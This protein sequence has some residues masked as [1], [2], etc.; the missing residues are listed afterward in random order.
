MTPHPW[1]KD[2]A[3]VAAG[4]I[5]VLLVPAVAMQFSREIDWGAMDF[6][7]AAIL[8][9]AA[10]AVAAFALRRLRTRGRRL[11]AMAAVGATVLVVWA[12][13]AVGL[14]H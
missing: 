1:R 12:E 2:L 4:T 3:L 7:A 6:L 8:L 11:W 9:F 5:A 10:G 13:L 14:F